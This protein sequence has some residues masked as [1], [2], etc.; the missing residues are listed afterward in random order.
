MKEGNIMLDTEKDYSYVNVRKVTNK[1]L[2]EDIIR[3][4]QQNHVEDCIKCLFDDDVRKY[5]SN[6]V[7][8]I[9]LGFDFLFDDTSV[10]Q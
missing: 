3:H 6:M 10:F 7:K 2:Q 8:A 4:L 9:L 5:V 1:E